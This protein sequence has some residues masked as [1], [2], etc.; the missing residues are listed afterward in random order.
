MRYQ[1]ILTEHTDPL[2]GDF[3][4]LLDAEG[5]PS[6]NHA[7]VFRTLGA[8]GDGLYLI[9]DMQGESFACARNERFDTQ[10]RR[11]WIQVITATA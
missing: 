9:E 4:Q 11:A 7:E 10:K 8:L 3:L 2:A 1:N 6:N 5:K